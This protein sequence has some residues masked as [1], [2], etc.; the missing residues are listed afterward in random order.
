MSTTYRKKG[1][2]HH[3]NAPPSV[4]LIGQKKYTLAE[5]QSRWELIGWLTCQSKCIKLSTRGIRCVETNCTWRLVTPEEGGVSVWYRKAQHFMPCKYFKIYLHTTTQV[6][7]KKNK[8]QRN[9]QNIC[10]NLL[11]TC[12]IYTVYTVKICTWPVNIL[13]NNI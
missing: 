13:Y 2:V 4:I 12:N 3:G 1:C 11:I 9:K 10:F 7:R 6:A 5:K 8:K